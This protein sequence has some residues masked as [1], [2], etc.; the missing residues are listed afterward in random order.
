MI[1]F[2]KRGSDGRPPSGEG[3]MVL[4]KA[5]VMTIDDPGENGQGQAGIGGEDCSALKDFGEGGIF[6]TYETVL[7]GNRISMVAGRD[8][9]SRLIYRVLEPIMDLE[10]NDVL[11]FVD[12]NKDLFL[13]STMRELNP[14]RGIEQRFR[15]FVLSHRKDVQDAVMERC[16]YYIK[17]K[18]IGAGQIDPFLVDPRVEDTTVS[19]E[20]QGVFVMLAGGDNVRE[21]YYRTSVILN[22]NDYLNMLLRVSQISSMSPSYLTPIVDGTIASNSDRVN[23]VFGTQVSPSGGSYTIRSVKEI[24]FT[25]A[26]L[27]KGREMSVEMVAWLWFMVERG[28]SGLIMGSTGSGKTTLLNAL[29]LFVPAGRKVSVIE[30]TR[31]LRLP[32]G[33][34]WTVGLTR[35]SGRMGHDFK[36]ITLHD[37]LVSALRQRPDYITV[38]EIRGSEAYTLFDAMSTG[39]IGYGTVHAGGLEDLHNRFA[40]NPGV[41]G[42]M[43]V[44]PALQNSLSF[45]IHVSQVLLPIPGVF[46]R[47]KVLNIWENRPSEYRSTATGRVNVTPEFIMDANGRGLFTYDPGND[48]FEGPSSGV[49]EGY[50]LDHFASREGMSHEEALIDLNRRATVLNYIVSEGSNMTPSRMYLELNYY[51]KT[52]KLK[53]VWRKYA[54]NLPYAEGV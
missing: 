30:D 21:G 33:T 40:S 10:M 14:E 54:V 8:A 37:Q 22:G 3:N 29:L 34:N 44:P 28:A 35:K 27:I 43:Y 20:G 5:S 26:N 1:N 47:R 17:K 48:S 11:S 15:S 39:H 53:D 51:S 2:W 23:L 42:S 38:G 12:R 45:I 9:S 32:D 36:P 41:E 49:V 16:L 50:L 18:F 13:M 52:K 25:V 6:G 24:P 19:G 7:Y 46:Q 4:S 31:E